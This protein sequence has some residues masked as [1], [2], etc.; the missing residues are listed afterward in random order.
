MALYTSMDRL[1]GCQTRRTALDASLDLM[2][3]LARQ[4]NAFVSLLSS[5][6]SYS[7]TIALHVNSI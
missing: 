6:T 7:T 3:A 1:D 2:T 4:H 5:F